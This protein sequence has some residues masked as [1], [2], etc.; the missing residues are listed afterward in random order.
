MSCRYPQIYPRKVI[1]RSA[2]YSPSLVCALGINLTILMGI[3]A[4][5]VP[6]VNRGFRI[7][8][9]AAWTPH[10]LVKN[11]SDN[12]PIPVR[13]S[14]TMKVLFGFLCLVFLLGCDELNAPKTTPQTTQVKPPDPPAPKCASA[15]R[16][17][18]VEIYPMNL[19]ADIAL[20]SCTGQLCRTWPW[21]V[22]SSAG[23]SPWKTYED[24]P[25][26]RDLAS[27]NP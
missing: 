10:L 3:V 26:C 17:E 23:N 16:F 18:K 4:H 1:A 7:M 27:V 11:S 6:G 19:R 21:E 22:K 25:L 8:H 15:H 2:F 13:M 5:S 14:S 9:R 24:A 12:E 20:D